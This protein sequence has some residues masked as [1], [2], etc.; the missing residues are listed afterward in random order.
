MSGYEMSG[1]EMSGDEMSGDEISGDGISGD[2]I[3]GDEMSG[4]EISGDSEDNSEDTPVMSPSSWKDPPLSDL[5]Y[6]YSGNDARPEV[7]ESVR[8]RSSSNDDDAYRQQDPPERI[9]TLS[10]DI[11]DRMRLTAPVDSGDDA[12]GVYAGEEMSVDT[13]SADGTE[14][15]E[16]RLEDIEKQLFADS[17][18]AFSKSLDEMF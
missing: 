18:D 11:L 16:Q 17:I 9:R 1:A 8:S 7:P 6:K 14:D 4:V 13:P 5:E 15:L 10:D 12:S 2:G 3:S